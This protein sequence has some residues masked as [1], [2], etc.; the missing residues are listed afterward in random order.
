VRGMEEDVFIYF[1][2]HA[3]A[4]AAINALQFQKY[5]GIKIMRKENQ[6]NLNAF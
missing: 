5:L 4:K 3:Q 6:T 2:N 1:N